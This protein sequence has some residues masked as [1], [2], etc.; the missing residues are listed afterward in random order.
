MLLH[1]MGPIPGV[2]LV[3]ATVVEAEGMQIC[4]KTVEEGA[5]VTVA[6]NWAEVP[7]KSVT[8]FVVAPEVVVVTVTATGVLFPPHPTTRTATP[9]SAPSAHALICRF[10]RTMAPDPYLE[11]SSRGPFPRIRRWILKGTTDCKTQRMRRLI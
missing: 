5:P 2:Q 7:S 10:L 8:E 6:S 4:Q 3:G 9:H 11:A 1:C